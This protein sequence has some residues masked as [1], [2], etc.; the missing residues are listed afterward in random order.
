M[1]TSELIREIFNRINRFKLIILA[2]GLVFAMLL[3]IYA[4]KQRTVFTAKATIFPLTSTMENNLSSN[5]LTGL[6]G[7]GDAPKSFSAEAA[8]N[9]IEL[10]LSRFVRESVATSKL[11]QF[12][13]TTIASLLIDDYNKNKSYFS[14]P[15]EP[16]TDSISLAVVG[17]ELLEP[18]IDAKMS[19]NGVFELYFSNEN[20]SLVSP[21]SFVLIDK[22]SQFYIDLKIK[23]AKADYNFTVKKIDSLDAIIKGVDKRAIQLQNT[24]FF[25]PDKLEYDIPRERVNNDKQR[26]VRQRDISLNNQEEAIWRLQK[27]TPIISVLDKPTEPFATSKPSALI[28]GIAGGII[29]CMLAS[30]LLIMNLLFRYAKSEIHKSLFGDDK[31]QI[32]NL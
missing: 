29:G 32:S 8:I 16:T 22:I 14:K 9:I 15:I 1:T 24:T 18:C 4:I 27:L 26:Y 20:K 17:G 13:N 7:L 25:A 12:N 10:S 30:I 21:I 31:P 2:V 23:K 11:P 28:Y 5:A 6:L 3:F 19:K